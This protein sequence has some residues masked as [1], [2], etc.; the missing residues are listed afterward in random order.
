MHN[1]YVM[2]ITGHF[3]KISNIIVCTEMAK[4]S[5]ALFLR[6]IY[7]ILRME[8]EQ[9]PYMSIHSLASPSAEHDAFVFTWISENSR[10]TD[11]ESVAPWINTDVL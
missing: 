5:R 3:V 1:L 4:A 9:I 7:A 10:L 8:C 11:T 6:N 2:S